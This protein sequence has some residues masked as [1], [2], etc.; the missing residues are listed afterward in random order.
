MNR[1]YIEDH[2][3]VARYLADQL[4]EAERAAF[5]ACYLDDP[6][7]LQELEAVAQL[8]AGLMRLRDSGELERLMKP[9]PWHLQQAHSLARSLRSNVAVGTIAA[10]ATASVGILLWLNRGPSNEPWMSTAPTSLIGPV[11]KP[12]Q[13]AS[14]YTILRTRGSVADAEI[15]LPS[16]AQ[17]IEL[18][19]LPEMTAVPAVYRMTLYSIGETGVA[20]EVAAVSGLTPAADELVPVYLDSSKLHPG[21][22]RLAIA[23]AAGTGGADEPSVFDLEVR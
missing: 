17:A 4:S 6:D 1:K 13:I 16:S 15:A 19:V 18:R 21:R 2:H 10:V 5:E 11:G 12:L 8:K 20:H 3:I 23:G 7:L 22:Y 14:T 9:R